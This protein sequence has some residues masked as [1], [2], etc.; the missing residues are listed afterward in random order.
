MSRRSV[1][2]WFTRSFRDL[3]FLELILTVRRVPGCELCSLSVSGETSS[4]ALNLI[5]RGLDCPHPG[6]PR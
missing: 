5:F 4:A 6:R 2:R 3:I 1:R